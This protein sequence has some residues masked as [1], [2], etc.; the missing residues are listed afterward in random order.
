MESLEKSIE[1]AMLGYRYDACL[2]I[3]SAY[4]IHVKQ[5][6]HT[7]CVHPDDPGRFYRH[8]RLPAVGRGKERGE[9]RLCMVAWPGP[10]GPIGPISL[11]YAYS[12]CT[13]MI[14]YDLLCIFYASSM[15]FYDLL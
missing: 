13:S 1:R 15:I 14:F 4:S 3:W 10:I 5:M 7:S 8:G 12:R 2:S 9:R 11:F 6:L